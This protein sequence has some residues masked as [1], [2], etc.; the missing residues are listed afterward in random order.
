MTY[1]VI[2]CIIIENKLSFIINFNKFII[3]INKKISIF[4]TILYKRGSPMSFES[5][6][7]LFAMLI[8]LII[9]II[10]ILLFILLKKKKVTIFVSIVGILLF[11]I[12]SFLN[13]VVTN[14]KPVSKPDTTPIAENE[15]RIETE[16][17]I[18]TRKTVSEI[19]TDI[20]VAEETTISN[21]NT[22]VEETTTSNTNTTVEETTTSNNKSSSKKDSAFKKDKE[23]WNILLSAE[24]E[25]QSF[26]ESCL[27]VTNDNLMQL[28]NLTKEIDNNLS[29]Y[30][31]SISKL[32]DSDSHDYIESVKDY[33]INAQLI[34][35]NMRK[36]IDTQDIK[37]SSYSSKAVENVDILLISILEKRSIYLSAS[38]I[39]I[40]EDMENLGITPN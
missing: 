13:I 40:E 18:E 35:N 37:Y 23:I 22:T 25:L 9:T 24:R 26:Q 32:S 27:N 7:L 33:I 8:E 3:E 15:T 31:S 21:I 12:L 5:I 14:T 38:G 36:F 34:V 16:T 29:D 28:Y 19:V 2:N 39:S 4:N 10:L 11:G 30:Y 20:Y 1:I 6:I 17:H